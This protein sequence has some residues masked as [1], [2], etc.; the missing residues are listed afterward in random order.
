MPSA[1][2]R[3]L[4]LVPGAEQSDAEAKPAF[5]SMV[6]GINGLLQAFSDFHKESDMDR[7]SQWSAASLQNVR[8]NA[9]GVMTWGSTPLT[10]VCVCV[11]FF[12]T[13]SLFFP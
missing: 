9:A 4:S 6:D 3:L 10:C 1:L 12:H 13:F 11:F 5:Q 8:V 2:R 7:F